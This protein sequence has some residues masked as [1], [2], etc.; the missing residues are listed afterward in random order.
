MATNPR[1]A[2]GN[3]RRK[4]RE[5][6]LRERPN[7]CPL[8]G[9]EIDYDAPYYIHVNGKRTV[10]PYAFVIDEIE[11]VSK[12]GNPYRRSSTQAVHAHCNWEKSDKSMAEFMGDKKPS[13]KRSRDW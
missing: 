2:N 12:G 10:N 3:A 6:Y 13:V 9:Q 7:P 8:C 1:Y 4:L 5:R 11:P